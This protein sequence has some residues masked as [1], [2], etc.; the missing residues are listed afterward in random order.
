MVIE[1]DGNG[2]KKTHFNI[3]GDTAADPARYGK[4]M[5]ALKGDTFSIVTILTSHAKGAPYDFLKCC[6]YHNHYC[7]GVTSGYFIAQLIA[8]KYPKNENEHYLWFACPPWC[9]DDAVSTMLDLTPGKKNLY[10]K[11]MGENQSIEGARGRWAGIMV[12]WN[13]K[14]K[15]GRAIALQFDW[16][17]V[18]KV[19]GISA[20]DFAPKGGTS[21]PAF[22]TARIKSSWSMIPYLNQPEQF[23]SVVK[24]VG[25]TPDM[26]QRMKR[27]GQD[28]YQVIGVTK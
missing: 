12:I 24:E 14:D 9:K 16:N 17:A 25:I 19:A 3:K 26:L 7:P 28:P 20:R 2:A 8:E 22:Y 11:D 23:V 18:Y 4:I 21:N 10:V 27:A 15:K 13:G 5:K 6:E 1:H